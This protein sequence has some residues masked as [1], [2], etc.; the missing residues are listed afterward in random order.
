LSPEA[1]ERMGWS[2]TLAAAQALGIDPSEALA[3]LPRAD[4]EA[5]KPLNQAV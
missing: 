5:Q 4:T 1:I 2:E 3:G